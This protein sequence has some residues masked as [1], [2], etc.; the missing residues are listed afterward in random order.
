MG[1]SGST[2]GPRA[3][4]GRVVDQQVPSGRPIAIALRQRSV[5]PAEPPILG[6]SGQ[7]PKFVIVLQEEIVV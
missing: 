7:R 4:R 5:V 2:H 6:S 3:R 1:V